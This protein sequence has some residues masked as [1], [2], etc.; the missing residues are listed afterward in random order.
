MIIA[1]LL[2]H[3]LFPDFELIAGSEGLNREVT[4]VSVIDAP[5]VDRW[6]RGG[7]LLIGSGYIFREAPEEIKSFLVRA[8]SRGVAAV[9][10]KLDRYHHSIPSDIVQIADEIKIP[11]FKIPL[12]YRWTDV[13]EIV[14]DYISK[15]RQ[16]MINKIDLSASS[17]WEEDFDLKDL[18]RE[19]SKRLDF[20]IL[21]TSEQLNLNHC[22]LPTGEAET[23]DAVTR[24]CNT[25][26]RIIEE[27][28]LPLHGQI[29]CH[30]EKRE[31]NP[32]TWFAIYEAPKNTPITIKVKLGQGEH[33]PS[34]RQERIIMRA[35]SM[36]RAEALEIAVQSSKR[37]IR[38][39]KLFEGL[40][41]DVYSDIEMIEANLR[42]MGICF[43][44]A[45]RIVMVS[46]TNE[47]EINEWDT[48]IAIMKYQVGNVWIGLLPFKDIMTPLPA[49]FDSILQS[50]KYF[51]LI[52]AL[53]TSPLEI[54]KSYTEASKTLIWVRK[55][56][57]PANVYQY[58]ELSLYAMLD[59][60]IR[61]PEADGVWKRYWSPLEDEKLSRKRS[62]DF[63]DLAIALIET[64]FN[65][66]TCA[67]NLHIH[68]N[69]VRNYIEELQVLLRLDFSLPNHRLG[70]ILGYYIEKAIKRSSLLSESTHKH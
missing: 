13:I 22:F 1:D 25:S 69:T 27:K 59:G 9:G 44:P 12:A 18:L 50:R 43:P 49:E 66:K 62:V 11:L 32:N 51:V 40:C 21:V 41:L 23:G 55:F 63:R 28:Q 2:K 16:K 26:S 48:N 4:A 65:A 20:P 67:D 52:G 7:E 61:L 38:R 24:F 39:E 34:A 17:F 56:S 5:D 8:N 35:M 60:L 6:M 37:T 30:L 15:E 54:S 64:D 36:L 58:A 10:I 47:S 68:Y 33:T 46:P 29:V 19:F 42:E 3:R 53:I 14:H 70:L 45:T 57:L 31:D